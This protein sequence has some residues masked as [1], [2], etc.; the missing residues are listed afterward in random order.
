MKELVLENEHMKYKK[1]N[2]PSLYYKG[3]SDRFSYDNCKDYCFTTF[4]SNK[5]CLLLMSLLCQYRLKK[6]TL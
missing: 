3:I 4:N 2:M 6:I 1:G 5:K